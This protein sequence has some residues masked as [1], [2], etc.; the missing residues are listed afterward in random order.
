MQK[1]K[2]RQHPLLFMDIYRDIAMEMPKQPNLNEVRYEINKVI[3][4]V[5]DEIGLWKEMVRVTPAT[6]V[7][8]IDLMTAINIENED[9]YNI[10][11]Y[12]R[13]RFDWDWD[14][15]DKVLRLSDNVVEVKELYIDDEEWQ[16]VSYET[17]QDTNNSSS[18]IWAQVGRF[19]YFPID[20]Y[21]STN[22][23]DIL[24]NKSYSYVTPAIAEASLIDLPES[25]RQLLISGTIYALT[26][27]PKY[28]DEDI[29]N[30]NKET[31]EREY[32]SLKFQYDD[33][34]ASYTEREFGY[35]Y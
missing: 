29:F 17:V 20:L 5:N 25:F 23:C 14:S 21:N 33:L 24:V 30:L 2:A 31:Y 11:D 7:S 10:E 34:E 6:I 19:I 22:M 12:A 18:H 32:K 4:R 15:N 9:T 1:D 16:Q 3:R 35:K 8:D 27:R 13:I 26:S 28:K